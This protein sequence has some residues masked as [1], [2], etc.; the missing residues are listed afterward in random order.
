MNGSQRN[1]ELIDIKSRRLVES[2]CTVC[3]LTFNEQQ[4]KSY[5]IKFEWIIAVKMT[6]VQIDVGLISYAPLTRY[7][8]PVCPFAEN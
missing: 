3:L 7:D 8:K 4:I 2:Q 5:Q 6:R 1:T